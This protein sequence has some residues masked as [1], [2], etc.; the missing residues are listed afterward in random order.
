MRILITRFILFVFLFLNCTVTHAQAL[1]LVHQA[2]A[3]VIK[4]EYAIAKER[5]LSALK[6]DSG[7][8]S[9][10]EGLGLLLF[11]YLDEKD[12][13]VPYLEKALSQVKATDTLPEL[14]L[15]YAECCLLYTSPS[16]RD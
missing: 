5:Y 6:I 13:A 11:E 8:Y 4:G 9:A 12:K 16:P 3:H 2:E 7:S 1:K 14:Y 15:A 10:N